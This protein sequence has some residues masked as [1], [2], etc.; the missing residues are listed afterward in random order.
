MLSLIEF[1]IV[2]GN[3]ASEWFGSH[4]PGVYTW[5]NM[6]ASQKYIDKIINA[7]GEAADAN[8]RTRCRRGN[9]IMLTPEVADDV[10]ITGDL[11]GHRRNFNLIRKIADLDANPKRHLVLQE[12]CH[13]G[14]TY[15]ENG[16]CMSHTMLEDVAAL[17]IKY[18]DRVHFILGN[19]ELAEL[20]DYP[21]QKNKQML[22][23]LFR[24]GLQQMY[25]EAA[26]QVRESFMPFLQTSPLA[27]KI[28]GKVFIS[29]SIPEKCDENPF[30]KTIFNR[31]LDPDEFWDQSGVFQLVW[32]RDYRE[33]NAKAFAELVNAEVLI[34]GHDPCPEGSAKPNDMQLII[35]CCGDEARYVII[36]TDGDLSHA[37]I[38]DGVTKLA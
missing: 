5:R 2:Y 32:G 14:P 21:I 13:G 29:H 7:F 17:K 10:M 9:V 37:A 19:H 26:D 38:C 31:E 25:G 20:T 35:D 16:G 34:N 22:N 12:V 15:P 33:E 11:H 3:R 36:P 4:A 28:S 6:V 23:L 18:P 24:L 27:V 1:S 8:Q 30:D